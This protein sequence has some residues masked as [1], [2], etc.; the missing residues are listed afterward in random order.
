MDLS[1]RGNLEKH[2]ELKIARDI[3][4]IVLE[5]A[6]RAG[7]WHKGDAVFHGG[8][9]L[10]LG[11]GSDRGSEDLDF[12]VSDDKASLEEAM[13][14]V[15]RKLEVHF[16]IQT[17]GA[18]IAIN[19]PTEPDERLNKWDIKW[20][21]PNRRGKVL[22]KA[23]FW[24]TPRQIVEA[25]ASRPVK[26]NA[27]SD[28]GLSVSIAIPIA[29]IKAIWADKV[30]AIAGR[31][32]LKWRDAYDLAYTADAIALRRLRLSEDEA[33]TMVAASAAVYDRDLATVRDSLMELIGS[34][35][36]DD[37]S[38]FVKDM[39]KWLDSNDQTQQ[40]RFEYLAPKLADAKREVEWIA[41]VIGARL[42][43]GISP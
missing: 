40:D 35:Q 16:T 19:P 9:S 23:E 24:K 6:F 37:V 21:H 7:G 4:L 31:P 27:Q 20:S 13:E 32:S 22:V 8:S 10:R 11:Y 17:P 38:T 14:A 29:E 5:E 2:E 28:T 15:R 3:H 34:G 36:L 25:Y 26:I 30:V 33:V 18:T 12:I 42:N 1:K 39:S 43:R 41:D